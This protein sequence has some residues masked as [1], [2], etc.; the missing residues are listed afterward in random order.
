MRIETCLPSLCLFY[1]Q[2]YNYQYCIRR[3]V[4]KER[5]R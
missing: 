3:N 1:K 4:R 2:S 5:Q